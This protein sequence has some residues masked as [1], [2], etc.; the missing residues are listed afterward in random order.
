VDGTALDRPVEPDDYPAAGPLRG[1]HG[2]GL[3]PSQQ[4]RAY[5]ETGGVV[6]R[7]LDDER[8]VEAVRAAHPAHRDQL[9]HAIR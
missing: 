8:T 2:Y 1:D 6:A 4:T 3:L 9:G 7:A 5:S